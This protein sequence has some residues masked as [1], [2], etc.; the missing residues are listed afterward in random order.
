[1]KAMRKNGSPTSRALYCGASV[2]VLCAMAAAMAQSQ[3]GTGISGS[4]GSAANEP[5]DTTVSELVVTGVRQSLKTSQQLK[6]DADTI[7]DSITPADIG[8]FPDKS[9]A[10][11]LQRVAG[12]TVNRFA[13]SDDTS[14][15]SAEPSGV[16]VRGLNQV[17][18]E[19]NGRDTFSANSSRGLGWG[20]VSPEL[21]GGVDVYKNQT[22]ELIEGGIAGS[23]NLRTRVP[24]DEA[25]Q[26]FAVTVN[27]NYGDISQKV[28]ADVSGLYA[29]R[30]T[31]SIGEFGLLADFAY[32]KVQTESEGIQYFRMGTYTGFDGTG[33]APNYGGG[34]KYIPSGVA[35][36]DTVYDRER[37]GFAIAGQWQ[38]FDKKFL[39]TAQYNRSTYDNVWHEHGIAT[40]GADILYG[41]PAHVVIRPGNILAPEPA[42]GTPDFT[43]DEDGVFQSGVMTTD[44]GWWG[45]SNAEAAQYAQNAEGQNFVNACYDWNGCAL[46]SQ[47]APD[48]NAITRYN[49]NRNMTN[50]AS[51]NLKWNPTDRIKMNFDFQRV[52]STVKNYDIEVGQYSYANVGVDGTGDHPILTISD[53]LNVNWSPGGLTN[54]SNYYYHHVMDHMEDSEGTEYAARADL[55][56]DIGTTWLDSLKVGVRYS[57][58]DQTVRWSAYNWANV[59]NNWTC[60]QAVYFNI[61]KHNP[62]IVPPGPGCGQPGGQAFSGYQQGLYEPFTFSD[63][64]FGG[65]TLNQNQFIFANMSVIENQAAIA[66][67]LG[68]PSLGVGSWNPLCS[69]AG[70]RAS[71]IPGTCYT[72]AEI[73]DVSEETTAAYVMLKFGGPDAMVGNFRVSGNIGLR[74]VQTKDVSSGSFTLP[75]PFTASQLA[76]ADIPVIP[77]QPTPNPPKTVGCY[78][79]PADIAFNSGGSV[80]TEADTTHHNWLPSFNLK[81][82]L[83]DKWLLRFA[84][85]RAMSRPDIGLLKNYVSIGSPTLPSGSNPSDPAWIKDAQG[86]ITGI[87][88]FYSAD[89]YNPYLKPTTAD[90]F[91]IS[92]ENYFA[93]VGSFS[94]TVF[95]KKF[96]DYIQYGTFGLDVTNNGV[97]RNV[98]VRGPLNGDGASVQGIELAYQRFFDFLPDPFNGLGIQTNFTV[99]ENKGITNSNLHSVNTPATTN[100]GVPDRIQID[101]LEGLSKYSYNIIGMYEKG[102]WAARLA[103]NWRSKFLVTAL[104]CC[105][106]LPVWS[107]A[108]GFLDASIRYRINDHFEINVEGSNLLNTKTILLQQVTD[109]DDGGLLTPNGWFQNDRRIQFGIRAK[110]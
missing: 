57:D 27:G 47:R 21:M 44:I 79:S 46:P 86:N 50:D 110:Y 23:I 65:G 41:Q 42:P 109:S 77:G 66:K 10:E 82:N 107:K 35:A 67:A 89:A 96:H 7:V 24:F 40:Y 104:D 95:Y 74:Y 48:F 56:Y 17:R 3:D 94:L 15:F 60:N 30:W 8:S 61:D 102:P 33:G 37:Q 93:D 36:R 43:F 9:V 22:A 97:T 80:L 58:R 75:N 32:S 70:N 88:L 13:A 51:I 90:Q 78:L 103:Y 99:V 4:T 92:L 81:I 85:S 106:Y 87:N 45:A 49:N 98:Q 83:T 34:T 62:A 76:C 59:S 100:A 68:L 31:T 14:H 26:V 11:A 29:N 25:G 16:I 2:M 64:F 53:P 55:Q 52:H 20:D 72:P 1:M 28:T 84:A 19:F 12:I 91:D 38:D 69:G 73:N 63:G 6:R 101:A 105:V 108:Q 5:V 54:P 71:E 18:S 39:L